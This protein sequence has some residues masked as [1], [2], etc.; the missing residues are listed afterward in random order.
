MSMQEGLR[1]LAG[2]AVD[3]PFGFDAFEQRRERA[4]S[5]RRAA[6]WS[7]ALSVSMLALVGILAL[8]TQPQVDRH[9]FMAAVES[10]DLQALP[11]VDARVEPPALVDMSRFELTSEL[12]DRIALL[13]AELSAARVRQAPAEQLRRVEGARQQMNESLQ[14]VSYAHALLSL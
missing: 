12:E 14:R 7:A 2:Q 3:P 5:R 11:Q 6:I 1:Q 4:Q 10:R 8:V 9:A 13:D